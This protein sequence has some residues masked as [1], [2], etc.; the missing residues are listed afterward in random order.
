MATGTEARDA[1]RGPKVTTTSVGRF[2][3]TFAVSATAVMSSTRRLRRTHPQVE[4]LLGVP[5]GTVK[6]TTILA[7]VDSN[8]T[9]FRV[10]IP[11]A[12]T[13]ELASKL[14]PRPVASLCTASSDDRTTKFTI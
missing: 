7:F 9:P 13:M 5:R 14:T 6:M 8:R 3:P 4:T 10:E 1:L 2:V 11:A 12:A